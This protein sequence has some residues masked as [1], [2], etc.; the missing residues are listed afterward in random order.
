[1]TFSKY[2]H[3]CE[4]RGT[5]NYL[6]YNFLTGAMLELNQDYKSR[7]SSMDLLSSSEKELLLENGFIVSDFDEIK[8]LKYG[9]K[10]VCTDNELLSILIAPTMACNFRCPYCF[11]HHGSGM[12]DQEVQNEIISFIEATI[13]KNKH[14]H[15]F[16]YWFGGEPLLGINIIEK[17]SMR[18]L[19]IVDKYG[20]SYSSAMSTNG[21]NLSEKNFAILEKCKLNR[22][23]ITLDGMREMNDKTRVL[24]N[25][26]GTFDVIVANL[27][28]AH[29]T[30]TIHIRSNLT[31]EN[32]EEFAKLNK[33]IGEIRENNKIDISLYGAHMSVY[34][35]NNENVDELELSMQEYSDALKKNNMIGTNKKSKCRFAFCDAAKVYSFCFDEK[36]NM[37]KCWNDIGNRKFSYDNV[38]DANRRGVIFLNNNALDY[39][40]ESF[41]DE[42]MEC[43]ILPICMG[44]CIKKRVI[45]HR[46]SCSPIKYNL[47]DYVNKKYH[48]Q[49][50]GEFNDIGN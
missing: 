28:N 45:E 46:K 32:I 24:A 44:G 35:F 1:M 23:Q 22:I 16:V 41:P 48:E 6:L 12:M 7:I 3:L 29:T 50:G 39:L 4:L 49:L 30:I 38:F 27:R 21:Y 13:K 34:D 37:Y 14:K 15:L 31:R 17:M 19:D 20:I 47:D 2:N 9:N 18:I 40:A 10:L 33:L 43:K 26:E 5:K 11:E 36:G 42:C 8:Y 25:G